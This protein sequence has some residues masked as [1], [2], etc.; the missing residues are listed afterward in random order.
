[1]YLYCW[2]KLHVFPW[3]KS[4]RRNWKIV[5]FLHP[6]ASLN[7]GAFRT[8]A[9]SWRKLPFYR[10]KVIVTVC[11]P[12]CSMHASAF[13]SSQSQEFLLTSFRC[14]TSCLPVIK[15]RLIV[16]GRL[17]AAVETCAGALLDRNITFA[18]ALRDTDEQLEQTIIVHLAKQLRLHKT[19]MDGVR[20]HS[21][22]CNQPLVVH[23]LI[24]LSRRQ[25]IDKADQLL[26]AWFS[27]LRKSAD[28]IVEP[29]HTSLRQK[30]GTRFDVACDCDCEITYKADRMGIGFAVGYS[31]GK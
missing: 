2:E 3:T 4:W 7:F 18:T 22:V 14:S 27:F 26:R 23:Y 21:A 17:Q 30:N 11:S 8:D 29:W 31:T 13:E 24:D 15:S 1:M 10:D 12:P 25:T 6:R 28:E 5:A 19:R 9:N 20:R 16:Q